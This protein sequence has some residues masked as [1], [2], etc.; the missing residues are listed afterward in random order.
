MAT[1]DKVVIGQTHGTNDP[2]RRPHLQLLM[3]DAQGVSLPRGE[4]VAPRGTAAFAPLR[5]TRCRDRP[6][7]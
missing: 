7:R 5:A 6:V 1:D 3:R 2:R 4:R